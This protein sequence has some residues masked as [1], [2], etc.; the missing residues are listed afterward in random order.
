MYEKCTVND[1]VIDSTVN[2]GPSQGDDNS[3]DR[4]ATIENSMINF[5]WY[6]DFKSM[7]GSVIYCG[8]TDDQHGCGPGYF[9]AIRGCCLIRYRILCEL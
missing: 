4:L 9:A 2:V 6:A 8:R 7:P 5:S 3:S 1:Y